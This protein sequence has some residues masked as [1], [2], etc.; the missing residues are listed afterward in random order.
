MIK[1]L[2]ILIAYI[3]NFTAYTSHK[4]CLPTSLESITALAI[5]LPKNLNLLFTFTNCDTFVVRPR[6]AGNKPVGENT[7]TS[8]LHEYVFIHNSKSARCSSRETKE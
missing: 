5:S 7:C 3:S 8:S 6:G 4:K 1:H 2:I